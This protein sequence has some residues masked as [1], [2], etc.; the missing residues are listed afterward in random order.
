MKKHL[1]AT[2]TLAALT[3]AGTA[4][5]TQARINSVGGGVKQYTFLDERNI[6]TLPAELVKYGAWADVEMGVG[7][8]SFGFHY[9]FSP[10]VV[11]AIY[12][13][14]TGVQTLNFGD[15]SKGGTKVFADGN[16]ISLG[17]GNGLAISQNTGVSNTGDGTTHKGT[18][19]L[20][21]DLGSARLGFL[22]A[23]WADEAR[24]FD[25]NEEITSNQGP[26]RLQLGIGAGF[27]TGMGDID[28][29]L[30]LGFALPT[31]EDSEGSA[32]DG[33]EIDIGFI[34]RGTFPFSGPHEL[35]PYVTLDVAFADSAATAD[36]STAVS[37]L[38]F[39]AEVGMDIR[40]N[41]AD[42]ITVQ[43]G[44]GFGGKITSKES[45]PDG[46]DPTINR[47]HEF[48][49]PF[50]S[51]AVDVKV[52]DWLDI[53]FGGRQRVY[54]V[55]TSGEDTNGDPIASTSEAKVDHVIATGVGINLPAG[56]SLDIEVSND[57]WKR[58]PNAVTGDNGTFGLSAALSKD[59]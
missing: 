39:G 53:R 24:S 3:L 16:A 29:A 17:T 32:V 52:F 56:V 43:P 2:A 48:A 23:A 19:I 5:A 20:G 44:I 40:L 14:S 7:W 46:G 33:K 27:G 13:T 37:G 54:W 10:T 1:L 50:Y 25:D 6:F 41:L 11:L 8:T 18:A 42:G 31:E 15:V 22:L 35:V 58:G 12:G 30:H 49:F 47:S 36:G 9:N 55:W 38:H 45:T 34:F 26:L 59:W 51:L 4:S 28:L 21:V 57:W